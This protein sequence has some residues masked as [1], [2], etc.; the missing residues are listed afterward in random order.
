M[1]YTEQANK[2]LKIA[3]DTARK[4]NHPYVGTEHLLLA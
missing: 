1:N 3:R 4:L 2:V